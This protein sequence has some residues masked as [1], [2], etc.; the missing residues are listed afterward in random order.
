MV[1]FGIA[2]AIL[3]FTWGAHNML[4]IDAAEGRP[5]YQLGWLASSLFVVCCAWRLARFNVT[6]M[7]PGLASRYFLGMPS[8]AA[9][10]VIA[11]VVHAFKTPLE[12][13]RWAVA[14]MSV[15]MV[16]AVLM[17]STVRYPSLKGLRLNRRHPS[18]WVVVAGL[19]VWFTFVYSEA[20]LLTLAAG[21]LVAGLTLPLLRWA[22]R[23]ST[24]TTGTMRYSRGI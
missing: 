18:L 16:V 5:V 10:A 14:W 2:P 23:A 22:R 13:W 9:A 15:V 21:Y 4:R 12:D 1:S 7:A 3:A 19:L 11:A 8:P 24:R 6:G 17:A 20:V